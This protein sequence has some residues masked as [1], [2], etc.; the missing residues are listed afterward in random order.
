MFSTLSKTKILILGTL[1]LSSANAFNLDQ[2][3]ILSFGKEL[4][5]SKARPCFKSLQCK[6]FDNTAGKSEIARY[7][8]FLLC[9]CSTAFSTLLKNFLPFSS[10]LKLSSANS[11]SWKNLKFVNWD[12]VKTYLSKIRTR[13]P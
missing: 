5:L 3:K 11:L 7:K 12:R 8:Q 4:I 10:N 6:S 1:I 13:G 9:S 2:S